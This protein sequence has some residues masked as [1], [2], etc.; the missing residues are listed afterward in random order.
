MFKNYFKLAIRNLGKNR[1]FSL[2]KIS[3][4]TAGMTAVLLIGLYLQHELSFDKVHANADRIARVTMEYGAAVGD[5]ET[6]ENTGNKVAPTFKADFPEVEEAVRVIRYKMIARVGEQLVEEDEVYF[7]DSSI[8]QVFTFPLLQGDSVRAIAQPNTVVLAQSMADKYFPGRDPMGQTIQLGSKDYEVTGIMAD[9]SELSQLQ[10]DFIA[11]FINLRD[12]APERETWWNANYATYFLLRSPEDIAGLDAKIPNY[13]KSHYS[14]DRYFGEGDYL[15]YHL[16]PLR[17]VHLRSELPG[18]FVPNGDISYLYILI[19]VGLLILLIGTTTYIN[20]TTATGAA[21]AREVSMQ[22]VLGAERKHL[23]AQHLSEAIL[24]TGLALGL[25]Y[26]LANL[27]LPAFNNLFAQ[28]LS[29]ALLFHPISIAAVISLGV[30][31]G[32]L[33]GTY[34][35]FVLSAYRVTD[36]MRNKWNAARSGGISIR[37]VLIVMQFAIAVFLIVCTIGLHKQLNYIRDRNLGYNK[38]QVVVLP[39]DGR[40][41]EKLDLIKTELKQTGA[42]QSASLSYETPVQIRGGYGIASITNPE[43]YKAVTALPADQDFL[44]AMQ[45]QLAAGENFTLTD[46]ENEAL[47]YQDD[48]ENIPIRSILINE[49]QAADFGWKPEEAVGQFV[50]FNGIRSQVGVVQDF[51]FSSLHESIDRL[52]IFPSSWG[53]VLL[54]KLNGTNELQHSLDL[55]QSKWEALA[56]HR[57]FSFHFLDEE[58]DQMYASENRT[59]E[60]ITTFSLLAILLACLG[61]FGLASFN[62][63]KRTKEIGIRKVLGASVSGLV[64]LLS[65][66]FIRLVLVSIVIAGPLAYWVL[67]RWLDNF[68]YRVDLHWSVILLAGLAAVSVAFAAISWQSIRAAL[69]NPVEALRSE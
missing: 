63:V 44:D 1:L 9:P 2:I 11:G 35:A 68:A 28:N 53:N 22:K 13:M 43:A 19:G 3:G 45:I 61:L 62:I 10:P 15:V 65:K 26:G 33:A 47:L 7:A 27:L 46:I 64:G 54:V 51:H 21:R 37:Q 59:S 34:P 69:G 25:G 8:F 12:A 49:Q 66:D 14:D 5:R 60:L 41:I 50:S 23:I 32:L 24:V 30:F 39:T 36:L 57:P 4:L 48:E 67:G 56:P 29:G 40:I 42:V 38:E 52:V 55:I 18:N 17:S 16:E 6:T 58:F 20:L 31:I